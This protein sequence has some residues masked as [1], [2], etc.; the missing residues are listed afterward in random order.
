[1]FGKKKEPKEPKKPKE[2][3]KYWAY[4][5]WGS[6]SSS[7]AIYEYKLLDNGVVELRTDHGLVTLMPGTPCR[8]HGGK[9]NHFLV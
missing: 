1:M 8:I 6:S 4:V 2:E 7:Y 9:W 3:T 5:G